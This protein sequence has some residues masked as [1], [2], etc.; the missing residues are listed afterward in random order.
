M[1]SGWVGLK[2]WAR[3]LGSLVLLQPLSGLAAPGDWLADDFETGTLW[4][5]DTPPGQWDQGASVSPSTLAVGAVG[6]HRGRYGFTVTDR[7]GE[8]GPVVSVVQD[9]DPLTSELHARTWLRLRSVSAFGGIVLMQAL[10]AVVELRLVEQDDGVVWELA[11]HHGAQSTYVSRRGSRVEAERWYLVE[12][13]AQGLGTPSGEARLWV[14]GV[15]QGA[16]LSG[17]DWNHPQY[18]VDVFIIGEPWTDTGTFQG[19]IDFDDV[20]VSA[21][22]Q[23]S[24]LELHQPVAASASCI[25]VDVSLRSS[26]STGPVPAPYATQVALQVLEGE[27]GFHSEGNC[28]APVTG[29]LLAAGASERRVYFLSEGLSGRATLEASH[30][31]FLPARLDVTAGM[32][33]EDVGGEEPGGPW[34]TD[35]GCAAAPGALVALPLLLV[36]WLRRRRG[37]R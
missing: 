30:P 27:G 23:A 32:G 7:T 13:S 18:E 34:T 3:V 25:A 20:R 4:P 1:R 22:P 35:L 17:R 33:P 10:P 28:Q 21:T 9:Q 8:R 11:T 31:D 2:S 19:S 12:F 36:P 16:P 15:P 6:A 29:A 14:D 5:S 24:R 37:R 26:A